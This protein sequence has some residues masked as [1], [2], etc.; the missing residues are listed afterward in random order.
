MASSKPFY[1]FDNVA[2][3]LQVGGMRNRGT[4]RNTVEKSLKAAWLW[5]RPPLYTANFPVVKWRHVFEMS[6]PEKDYHSPFVKNVGWLY[7]LL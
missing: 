3:G 5:G 2:Y 6:H 4:I 7:S 1:V